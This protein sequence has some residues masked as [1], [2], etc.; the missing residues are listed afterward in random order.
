MLSHS[1]LKEEEPDSVP[2][3]Q[4]VSCLLPCRESKQSELQDIL[5]TLN[6]F[7]LNARPQAHYLGHC[8][9]P[10]KTSGPVPSD[11]LDRLWRLYSVCTVVP[12]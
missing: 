6:G 12:A 7:F 3:Y 9:S 11:G 1:D 4:A 10:Q 5:F 2:A 8:P